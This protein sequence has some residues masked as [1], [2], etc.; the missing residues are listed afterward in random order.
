MK[1]TDASLKAFKS[2]TERYE[3]WETNGKGFGLRVSPAGRKTF[4]FMYRFNGVA[5]RMTIGTYPALTLSEAHELHAKARQK[6]EKGID[7]GVESVKGKRKAREAYTVIELV[8]DYIERHAKRKKRSWKEDDRVLRKDV[9]PRW[10]KRKAGSITRLDVVNLLDKVRDR[11][12]AVGG[13]GVQ[14]NRTLEIIRKMFNFGVGRSIVESNPCAVIETPA[15]ENKRDRIL[16]ENEIK[17]F[18]DNIDQSRMEAGTCLLL[19]LQFVT[20]QRRGEAVL[21]EKADIDLKSRWWTQPKEKVKNNQAHRV[22]LTDLAMEIIREALDLSGDSRWLFPG[23]YK[24]NHITPQ[25][26]SHALRDAQINNP[27]QKLIDVFEIPR[28]TPHDLRRTGATHATGAGVTRFIIGKVL[29]H[30]D[31][32]VT[33]RYDLHKYDSEIQGA[34]ETWARKLESIITGHSARKIIKLR[35]EI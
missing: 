31:Q 19:R 5:R 29:N 17:V 28:F 10:G 8:D 11:A 32:S 7:P 1:F 33:S 27:K 23:R 6:L 26:V 25:A 30:V 20:M 22:W 13:R 14:A 18:W 3:A 35:R 12:E 15:K 9:V 4:I 16:S 24:E 21:I 2:K 34:L